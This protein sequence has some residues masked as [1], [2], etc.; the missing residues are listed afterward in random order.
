MEKLFQIVDCIAKG[1]D[2][3]VSLATLTRETGIPKATL[4]RLLGDL[5]EPGFVDHAPGGY[6][7]GGRLFDLGSR[8]PAYR[9]LREAAAPYLEDLALATKDSAHLAIRR[10]HEVQYLDKVPGTFAI[11]APTAVGQRQ[12]LYCTALGKLLLAHAPARTADE[13]LRSRLRPRTRNTLVMPAMLLR[14]VERARESD[15]AIEME[16][17]RPGLGCIAAPVRDA[18]GRV[19]AAISLSGDPRTKSTP[20]LHNRLRRAAEQVSRDLTFMTTAAD[21]AA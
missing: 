5:V 16:E 12:P 10:G 4:Y 13:V 1:D 20:A 2:D 7:L 17:F 3:A 15:V 6:A 21:G 8:V 14:S 18:R 9:H 19:V 11:R